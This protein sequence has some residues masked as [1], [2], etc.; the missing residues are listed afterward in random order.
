MPGPI[1]YKNVAAPSF[2]A[3]ADI[4]NQGNKQIQNSIRA[5]GNQATGIYEDKVDSNTAEALFNIRNANSIDALNAQQDL[6]TKQGLESRFRGHVDAAAVQNA[7]KDQRGEAEAGAIAALTGKVTDAQTSAQY[8]AVDEEIRNSKLSD[9]AK[10][11]LLAASQSSF[12][13]TQDRTEVTNERQR[14][15][16]E[17]ALIKRSQQEFV[18]LSLRDYGGNLE[19]AKAAYTERFAGLP[20]AEFNAGLQN[21]EKS[22]NALRAKDETQEGQFQS[23]TSDAQA[24]QANLKQQFDAKDAQLRL[25]HD[26]PSI[27]TDEGKSA[28]DIVSEINDDDKSDNADIAALI[29]EAFGANVPAS[30]V[31]EIVTSGVA[32]AFYGDASERSTKAAIKAIKEKYAKSGDK[33]SKYIADRL[34]AKAN[35]DRFTD[36]SNNAIKDFGIKIREYNLA[37]KRWERKKENRGKEYPKPSPTRPALSSFG[38][39]SG[40]L[41]SDQQALKN[42][43]KSILKKQQA[44]AAATAA[45]RE[46]ADKEAIRVR[47]VRGSGGSFG[48]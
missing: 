22:F 15:D 6:T 38:K 29:T 47:P 14:A 9:P 21:F 34:A 10:A 28:F 31:R 12:R 37:K 35:L 8:E 25:E 4:I 20:S 1:T 2:A 5:L 30:L 13:N 40:T 44:E 39:V 11:K 48:F 18:E 32:K 43:Q 27:P 19:Q 46:K 45:A 3:G 7:F 17:R 41:S 33:M 26:I 36:K 42:I 23:L 24:T 16:A